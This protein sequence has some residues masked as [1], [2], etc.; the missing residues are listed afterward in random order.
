MRGGP[1]CSPPLIQFLP[2][3]PLHSWSTR[4]L[5]AGL[6]ELFSTILGRIGRLSLASSNAVSD[7]AERFALHPLICG[8]VHFEDRVS[9]GRMSWDSRLKRR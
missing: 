4:R 6:S 5:A 1:V 2:V 9:S 3:S 7:L 8:Q